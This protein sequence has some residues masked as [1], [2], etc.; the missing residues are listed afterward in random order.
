LARPVV[1]LSSLIIAVAVLAL[2]VSAYPSMPI[3]IGETPTLTTTNQSTYT[4]QSPYTALSTS[5][6]TIGNPSTFTLICRSGFPACWGGAQSLDCTKILLAGGYLGHGC[7]TSTETE[8]ENTTLQQAVSSTTTYELTSTAMFPS[9]YPTTIYHTNTVPPYV[10][11]GLSSASFAGA[12]LV[13][14]VL[15]G[16]I[17]FYAAR[18]SKGRHGQAKQAN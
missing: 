15:C 1:L 17:G 9:Y 16:I 12:A 4:N 8:I 18:P 13:V 3:L 10:Y 6:S 11:Y 14:L 2:A 5:S 7:A